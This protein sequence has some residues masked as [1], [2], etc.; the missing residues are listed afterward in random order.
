MDHHITIL[1]NTVPGAQ[2]STTNKKR[3]RRRG[4]RKCLSY[5]TAPSY[6]WRLLIICGSWIHLEI[7]FSPGK[8]FTHFVHKFRGFSE[9][10]KSIY[11]LQVYNSWDTKPPDHTVELT[12]S[13]HVGERGGEKEPEEWPREGALSLPRLVEAGVSCGRKA[14]AKHTAAGKGRREMLDDNQSQGRVGWPQARGALLRSPELLTQD[15]GH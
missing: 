5:V 9:S 8:M 3:E 1:C 14:G 13:L 6:S 7:Y 15:G 11:G 4:E 2:Q 10:P 12:N